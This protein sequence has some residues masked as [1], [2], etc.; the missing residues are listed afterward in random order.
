MV[1]S[2]FSVFS[3]NKRVL[4]KQTKNL[5]M[6]TVSFSS[7]ISVIHNLG[8]IQVKLLLALRLN[9][10]VHH[11]LHAEK[12]TANNITPELLYRQVLYTLD[13]LTLTIL[14]PK[15]ITFISI[16]ICHKAQIFKF[17]RR[18]ICALY[19]QEI[20]LQFCTLSVKATICFHRIFIN[21]SELQ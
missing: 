3:Y 10:V 20:C 8:S 14:V 2:P 11:G 13:V 5:R 12:F 16:S 19:F 9:P 4:W 18:I 1:N 6:F 7:I 15:D 17:L 21:I